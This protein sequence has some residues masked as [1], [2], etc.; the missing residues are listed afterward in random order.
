[1]CFPH[2]DTALCIYNWTDNGKIL[3]IVKYSLHA[4]FIQKVKRCFTVKMIRKLKMPWVTMGYVNQFRFYLVLCRSRL[5]E[6]NK[7]VVS[8]GGYVRKWVFDFEY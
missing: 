8:I 1:L 2:Y 7:F 5:M 4:S 3:S 6:A